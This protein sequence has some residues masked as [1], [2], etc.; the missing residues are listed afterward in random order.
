MHPL[1]R[2]CKDHSRLYQ[3]LDV[4][5]E[6]LWRSLREE[7]NAPAGD[8]DYRQLPGALVTERLL[9]E[10]PHSHRARGSIRP[11]VR[12]ALQGSSAQR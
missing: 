10:T 11:R 1:Q 9:E 8:L 3:L 6:A 4:N 7:E 2:F 12:T 5:L